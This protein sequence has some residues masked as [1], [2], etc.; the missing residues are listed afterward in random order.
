MNI[1]QKVLFLI[2]EWNL[3]DPNYS[4][5]FGSINGKR[6]LKKL[7]EKEK[8]SVNI[9]DITCY[10]MPT[11]G[12]NVNLE[13]I[14]LSHLLDQFKVDLKNLIPYKLLNIDEIKTKTKPI[15]STALPKYETPKQEKE[16][17][18]NMNENNITEEKFED[19][20]EDFKTIAV[21]NHSHF[22]S[23]SNTEYFFKSLDSIKYIDNDCDAKVIENGL[24]SR[25]N[26]VLDK[27]LENNY[28]T[29]YDNSISAADSCEESVNHNEDNDNIYSENEKEYDLCEDV[30][31]A[32]E[33][34]DE[35]FITN[36]KS[37]NNSCSY[38]INVKNTD[39]I[40][41]QKKSF[42]GTKI[43]KNYLSLKEQSTQDYINSIIGEKAMTDSHVIN[44]EK[45]DQ[46]WANFT[47]QYL[48]GDKYFS[49][50]TYVHNFDD[51][52]VGNNYSELNTK[53]SLI[54]ESL[55]INETEEQLNDFVNV[56]LLKY[57]KRMESKLK[58]QNLYLEYG[59]SKVQKEIKYEIIN[60]FEEYVKDMSSHNLVQKWKAKQNLRL[61]ETMDISVDE[62]Q[63]KLIYT[64]LQKENENI[65]KNKRKNYTDLENT[66]EKTD[67][68]QKI[69][70]SDQFDEKNRELK[71]FAVKNHCCV[72]SEL[73]TSI[74]LNVSD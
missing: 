57:N 59:L 5:K 72:S 55:V 13:T 6:Y 34:K 49:A 41:E 38:I 22:S 24:V 12:P 42:S 74:S 19:K 54:D 46:N 29:D 73:N 39:E 48:T 14:N 33:P 70:T 11:P 68:V 56:L 16:T 25:E 58:D 61:I 40:E 8:L 53:T 3:E 66:K 27:N 36:V 10:L 7:I 67:I 17:V 9:E 44:M 1:L 37:G 64:K 52:N 15:E 2:R 63:E 62:Y 31:D 45:T 65:S 51:Q 47:N 43:L 4:L 69:F 28:I 26:S 60:E 35:Q 23:D 32:N 18:H 21:E 20:S 30:N 50:E 71:N